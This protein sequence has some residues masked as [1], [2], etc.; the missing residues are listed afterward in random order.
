MGNSPEIAADSPPR[1]R[2][3]ARRRRR[4]AVALVRCGRV[5]ACVRRAV[6]CWL[7]AAVMG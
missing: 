1:R 3:A 5:G 6:E 7:L 4:Q 2:A